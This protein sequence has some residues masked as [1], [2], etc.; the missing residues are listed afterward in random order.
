MGWPAL[1]RKYKIYEMNHKKT[2]DENDQLT[3]CVGSSNPR[4]IT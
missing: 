3:S 2:R 1:L 4:T